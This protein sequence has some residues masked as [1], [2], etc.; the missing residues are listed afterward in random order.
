MRT[1]S[2][3]VVAILLVG[4]TLPPAFAEGRAESTSRATTSRPAETETLTLAD[5]L[6]FAL[7]HSPH[8]EAQSMALRS[9]EAERRQAGLRA[10]PEVGVEVDDV[11]GRGE[12]RSFDAAATT[13]QLSHSLDPAGQRGRRE[14][15]A[16]RAG[17]FTSAMKYSKT[18]RTSF[19]FISVLFKTATLKSTVSDGQSTR[20]LS[21]RATTQNSTGF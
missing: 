5:A 15:L 17:E 19:R 13:V 3:A 14:Q 10:N 20:S 8:L 21:Q 6:A 2:R 9:R 12:A 18:R 16:S 7:R 11:G 1:T 4:L